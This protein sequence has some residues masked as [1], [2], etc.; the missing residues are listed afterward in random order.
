MT[1]DDPVQTRYICTCFGDDWDDTKV[2]IPSL[3]NATVFSMHHHIGHK[4][5]A[6]V[7]KKHRKYHSD[8][9]GIR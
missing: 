9:A 6:F 2:V 7:K 5:P 1:S 3:V 4:Y 8:G